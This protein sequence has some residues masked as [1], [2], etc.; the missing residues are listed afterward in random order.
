M[1]LRNPARGRPSWLFAALGVLALVLAAYVVFRVLTR[2]TSEPASVA[3]AVG[4]FRAQGT[5]ARELPPALRGRAPTPGVY[6]YATH[7]FEQSHA[8]GTRRHVYPPRTTITVTATARGCL[9]LRWDVLATRSDAVLTCPRTDGAWRLATQSESHEFAGHRDRRTYVCTRGSTYLPA[10][11]APGTTWTSRCAIDG[12]T[13]A[14]SGGVLGP[15]TVTLAGHRTR[16]LLLRTT[17]RISG[18]TT[19]T[20]T[21]LT[22]LLPRTR[23]IVRRTLMNASSTDTIIGAVPYVERATL[24]LSSPRPR[25]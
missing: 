6:V 23:L 24:A 14:D 8:L 11:L 2:E 9:R 25:R 22:W 15:R 4:R 13:T 17:T 18:D 1:R 12:T 19:G 5:A 3:G 16:T 10:T 21:T 20:G 7:G